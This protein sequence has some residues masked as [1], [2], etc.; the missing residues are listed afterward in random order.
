MKNTLLRRFAWPNIKHQ[1]F[2]IFLLCILIPL[3][4]FGIF[5]IQHARSEMEDYYYSLA[6]SDCIRVTSIVFD[7]TTTAFTTSNAIVGSTASM[8]MFGSSEPADTGAGSQYDY[9]NTALETLQGQ[10]AAISKITVYTN[11]PNIPSSTMISSETGGFASDVWYQKIIP[12]QWRAWIC[13]ERTDALGRNYSELTL[14]MRIGSTDPQYQSYLVLGIDN[15]YLRNMIGNDSFTTLIAVQGNPIFYASDPILLDKSFP[16]PAAADGDHRYRG[17]IDINGT[18]ELGYFQTFKPYMTDDTFLIEITDPR[19]FPNIG[20]ITWI[21]LMI[22]AVTTIVP[23]II[24][25]LYS[26]FFSRRLTTLKKAMHQA[27]MG[28]YDIVDHF[29]GNDELSE[30]FQDLKYTVEEIRQ[31]DARY[32]EARIARQQLE[33]KQQ[34]TEYKLLASQI[35]PHF[36]YNTLET[37]RMQ[38]LAAGNR[39]VASSIK[40]L[41]K[42]MHYILENTSTTFTTLARE[43]DYIQ[44]YLSIQHLRFGSRVNFIINIEKG[45][46]PEN[47]WILPLL[48][49]PAIENAIVHGLENIDSTGV[50]TVDIRREESFLMIRIEDNGC[51]MSAER[52]EYVQEQILNDALSGGGSIGL[53]NIRQR[54]KLCYGEQADLTIDSVVTEGTTVIIKL[55]LEKTVTRSPAET[56][57]DT[58]LFNGKPQNGNDAGAGRLNAP[59]KETGELNEQHTD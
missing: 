35:N 31:K 18:E 34:Q 1:I 47:Y 27:R 10:S 59:E 30:T 20:N 44:N 7:T 42:S 40:L 33:N 14:V 26:N 50:V 5:A 16:A 51:G 12:G 56:D 53:K 24:V 21:Y 54:I 37:I 19:A 11:N 3:V 52:L 8:S 9:V 41:G 22:L 25:F 15:N 13:M 32:Y 29:D 39:E 46:D 23:G 2:Y 38:A 45:I 17:P 6:E 36:L 57:E 43:L 28:S 49:Q 58:V 48:L 4:I 55:P